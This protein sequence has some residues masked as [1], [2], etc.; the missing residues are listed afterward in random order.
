MA[1]SYYSN[2]DALQHLNSDISCSFAQTQTDLAPELLDF[3]NDFALTD[4]WFD[5]LFQPDDT[6]YPDNYN[7]LIPDHPNTLSPEPF[8]LQEYESYNYSKRQKSYNYQDYY[9]E[10]QNGLF[11]WYIPNPSMLQD[12]S[13]PEVMVPPFPDFS[14]APPVYS[15]GSSESVVKKPNGG[16]LSAQSIAARQRRR[17][18]TEKTQELGKLI[19]GGQKMNT[20]EMFQAA[21]KYINYLQAQVGILEFM[22]SKQ[23]TF[24]CEELHDLLES[25]LIQ[26]KLYSTD[27]CLV[28]QKFVQALANDHEIQPKLQ[29]LK[30]LKQL[31]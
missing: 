3:N 19:P 11:C 13:S 18:I 25:P 28:P 16:S 26:E 23:E 20:A 31:I 22:G 9:S 12:F 15:S 30:E 2:W 6:F 21:Y 4:T 7:A 29:V 1:L 8:L 27:K 14:T 10:Y 5:P 17:K 24:S